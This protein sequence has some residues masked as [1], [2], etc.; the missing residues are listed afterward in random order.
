MTSKTVL[1]W[2]RFD[3]DYS[4]NRVLRKLLHDLGWTIRDFRPL[5]SRYAVA[6]AALRRIA[7]PD[8]VWVPCFRQRD[9]AAATA[10]AR[11]RDVPILFD[12]LIS[13]WDKQVFERGKF[14]KGSPEARALLA[15]E[16]GLFQ[17]VDMVVADTEPHAAFLARQFGLAPDRLAVIPVG[18][19]ETLFEP[20]PPDRAHQGPVEVLFFGSF[21]GL[22][23]PEVIVEAAKLYDGP[24]VSWHLLGAGPL[25]ADCRAAAEGLENVIFEPWTDY[26]R[27]PARI[28]DADI[29]LGVFGASEKAGRV[30]PNKVYQALA[31]GRPVITRLS[32]A[33]PDDLDRTDSGIAFIPPG[34]A[35]ALASAVSEWASQRDS[36]PDLSASAIAS[37]GCHFGNAAIREQLRNALARLGFGD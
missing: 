1:W 30:I 21:I 31:C 13:A 5:L 6:E 8:L 20:A 4:R 35:G 23:G 16:Q 34:D 26:T 37:Y 2:G 12:P 27:L 32:E 29:L 3:P 28:Q 15:W 11:A 9:T 22:Q 14:A 33:Y 19:E 10:W 17:G 25:L 18:A 24:P 7:T 36:L